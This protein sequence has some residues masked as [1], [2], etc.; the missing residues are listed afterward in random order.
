[1]STIPNWVTPAGTL[2]TIPEGV[3]YRI[4]LLAT[5]DNTVRYRVIAGRLPPGIQINETGVLSGNPSAVS[6]VQGVPVDVVG[7][8]TSQFAVRAYTE[9][10]VN[11]VTVIDKLA[12]RTFSLTISGISTVS[13]TTPAGTIGTYFDGSQIADLTVSY[14]D[15]NI[16]AANVVTLIAGALPTGLTVSTAGIISGYITPNTDATLT[17]VTYSFTLRVS[18]GVTSDT[19]TFNILVYARS[20]MTADNTHVTADNTF[21]TADTAPVQPPI[22]TTPV[23]SIGSTR[24]DNFY[25][26]EFTGLDFANNPFEFINT[27]ALPPGLTLDPISGWMY[28]Y[29]PFEGILSNEYSFDLVVREVDNPANYSDPYTFSLTIN[30]PVNSDVVWLTPTDE[31]E[32]ARVPSSLGFIDNGATST[33]YVEAVNVSG[34][35]LQ[36]RLLSGSDS[37][38]PQGLQLLT[39]GHIAGRV[40]FDTFCLDGGTTVF[41]VN[42]NTVRQ[43]TT[44]DMV[45]TFTVNAFS[46]NGL[47]NVNKTFS[48]TV[49]RRYQ[50][51]YDNLYIQAMPPQDDRDLLASLLQNPTIFTPSLIYRADDPNFG[52]ARNVVYNHAYGLTAATYDDYVASLNL[53]HYWKNLVLGNIKTAQALDDTGN[54]IYEVVYSEVI[55]NL[56]NNAGESVD[57]QVVLAFPINAN[58]STEIVSAYPNSLQNMR[59]QVI[60]VVG[61]VSNVLP[62]WMLSRQVNGRVLGF[63]PAWVIAYTAPGQSGQ[64]AYNIQT[65]FGTQ[66]NLVDFKADR[67]ELDNFLTKNWDRAGQHWG[68]YDIAQLPFP[69]SLTTFDFIGLPPFDT[70]RSYAVGDIVLYQVV[71]FEPPP[72]ADVPAY[73]TNRLYICTQATTPGIPPTNSSYWSDRGNNLASWINDADV[74][75]TWEDS[76]NTLATWTYATPPGTTFDGG[77]MQFTAPVDMYSNNNTTEYDKYLLFPKIDILE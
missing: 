2:G 71:I 76:F 77:S 72:N 36:Y 7:D 53:N 62:R 24:S 59:D 65:Q 12:D 66:L 42:L 63:T 28:G 48:I 30:G 69:P 58:D 67:Y 10:V 70:T 73:R 41:D 26:F 14:T 74:I 45:A 21:I 39:S 50:E 52:V 37:R 20:T 17:S 19:R 13:W 32:R 61:Q 1:M 33:F 49:V 68:Y 27:T 15:P 60:D 51:P 43:P 29:V 25:A 23:G 54:V 75:T 55:D 57:K 31:V 38:L 46:V 3:F 6:T 40:S 34:I 56:V 35:S 47:V 18:N 22:I 5:S 4:P 11:G 44:F 64:I 9:R 8:T 16:S